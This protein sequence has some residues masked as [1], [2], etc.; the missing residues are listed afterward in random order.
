MSITHFLPLSEPAI[1]ALA[2]GSL[3]H[4]ISIGASGETVGEVVFNTAMTGYQEILTDPSY[5][6]QIVT[7]TYPHI[8]NV[9][10]NP[11]DME[12]DKAYAAGLII[13]EL[14]PVVSNWR[15]TQS[16]PD[17][18]KEQH[19]V[20]IA[21]IDTR[22]LTRLLR[23]KG[24]QNG[25]IMT[26]KVDPEIVLRKARAFSD[27]NGKDLAIEV[28]CA[29]TYLYSDNDSDIHIVVYDFGVKRNILRMLV[30][31]RCKV[32]VVP[33]QTSASDV[34]KLKPDGILLSN[35]PGDPAACGYAI[36]NIQELLMK[37]IPIF[38]I[39]LGF[40]LLALACGAKTVKMKF[41]H[42]GANHPVQE[43]IPSSPSFSKGGGKVFIT[44]QNHGFCIDEKTLPAEL[45]V[46]HVSLFD[47]TLQGFKH[48]T[49]PVFAFQGHPEAAPGPGDIAG[50]FDEF[51]AKIP[52]VL[53]SQN[54]PPF[55]KGVK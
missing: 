54:R 47:G 4:G 45:T 20:S 5:A 23:E 43:K 38:G 11:D 37:K 21:N 52:P 55:S 32:T 15:A 27:L 35:G 50:L 39:C 44:S 18:L 33:A 1:L 29:Q 30:D 28:S 10:V 19:I 6:Q 41:G 53:L 3:F 51:I 24:A 8:G 34:L 40:Q 22:C 31:R 36:K 12:S 42:H 7:L 13:R 2:D 48:N 14:S 16:L 49:L 9:G 26:G 17:F 46:T 25:C